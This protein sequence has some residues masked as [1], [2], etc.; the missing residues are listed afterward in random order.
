MSKGFLKIILIF[1]VGLSGGIFSNQL[2]WPYFVE[3]PLI[4]QYQLASIPIS[5]T[6]TKE[7]IIQ[8]ND[9]LQNSI[10]RIEK[11]VVGIKTKTK[12]GRIISGSGLVVT[13]DGLI[14]TL[15]NIVS[16]GGDF[17]FFVNGETPDWQILKRDAKNNLALIKV[18]A[19]GLKT[20]GFADFDGIKLGQRVFLISTILGTKPL[21]AV[22]EGIIKFFT[23]EYIRTNI[24][25]NKTFSGSALFDI[26]GNLLGLN[27]I[28]D[29]GRVTAIPVT[30]IRDFLGY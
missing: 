22:N 13:S 26:N 15:S 5:I 24:I 14:I 19:N 23:P 16:P 29:E 7:V 4:D 3:R 18:D 11:A 25:E 20:V 2:L 27:T 10:E 28:D 8:E 12:D 30:K 1:G 21:K 6:E 17:V 9:A